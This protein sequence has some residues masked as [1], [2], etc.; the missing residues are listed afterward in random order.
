MINERA[1][2]RIGE[3]REQ[4]ERHLIK[5]DYHPVVRAK[6]LR[7][8]FLAAYLRELEDKWVAGDSLDLSEYERAANLFFKVTAEISIRRQRDKQLNDKLL[9][10]LAEQRPIK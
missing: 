5:V 3:F 7:A 8:G 9:A 10:D 4:L 6:V 2:Q 1:A